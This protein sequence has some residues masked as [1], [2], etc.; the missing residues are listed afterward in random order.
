MSEYPET[1]GWVVTEG[2]SPVGTMSLKSD[3][4]GYDLVHSDN[5]L[6]ADQLRN[7]GKLL[8]NAAYELRSQV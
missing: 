2:W 1:G 4:G 7:L 3:E 8:I 6:N 5:P